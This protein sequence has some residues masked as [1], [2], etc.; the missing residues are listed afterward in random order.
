M[1]GRERMTRYAL[2]WL[3]GMPAETAL[4][5]SSLILGGV[6][7]RL[8]NLRIAFAH[9]G[10]AFPAT[11]GRIDHAH[12]ARPDLVAQ[13]EPL[14][15]RRYLQRFYVDS[16]VHDPGMLRYL[17]GL[18]G[19]ERIALGSDYPFPLGETVPGELIEGLAELTAAQRQ[20]LLAGTAL[21]FLG[22][23][24]DRFGQ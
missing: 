14:S 1:L 18:L 5:I 9:G 16:L 13:Q 20:R 10:G 24:E 7:G 12:R 6:L 8:P 19:A 2:P 23:S 21:E 11:I 4:A 22:L 17:V 3:V 15:P